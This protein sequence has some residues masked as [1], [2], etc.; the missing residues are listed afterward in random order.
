MESDEYKMVAWSERSI[1]RSVFQQ[2]FGYSNRLTMDSN[3]SGVHWGVHIGVLA[4]LVNW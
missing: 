2:R 4:G 3:K 1:Q